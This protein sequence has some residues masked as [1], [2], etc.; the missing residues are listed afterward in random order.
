MPSA[1]QTDSE[2]YHVA[3]ALIDHT[4][5]PH[6]RPELELR[7]LDMNTRRISSEQTIKVSEKGLSMPRF[8]WWEKEYV[9]HPYMREL[10][11]K[12]L[13][14]RFHDIVTNIV[15][16]S[17][18]GKVG[19]E[20]ALSG[21]EW[22]RYQHHVLMEAKARELPY[23]LFLDKRHARDW[24]RDEFT[25][26]VKGTHSAG[27]FQAVKAWAEG[28]GNH[29]FSVVKYGERRFMERFL[30]YGEILV[31][32][33]AAYNHA[34]FNRAQRDDENSVSVFGV[35]T[36]DGKAVPANDLPVWWGNRL[37]MNRYSA[38]TDRDYMLYCMG[39]TLS[40]TLF[41]QFGETY[42]A[43]ILIHD[44]VEFAK[45]M[46]EGTRRRFPS[47]AFVHA[48]GRTTYIDPLNAIPP[49][50]EPSKRTGAIPIPFLKHFRHAYQEE[51]R[52]VWVPTE[53]LRGFEEVLLSIGSIEDIAE[54]IC[55]KDGAGRRA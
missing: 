35:R 53:P 29:R 48:H 9:E 17:E 42:D 25:S 46:D 8:M 28:S 37:S 4:I 51:Y 26:S 5:L 13:N 38:S 16:T 18:D 55:L 30:R 1:P 41:S 2:R 12:D 49:T 39:T 24:N 43:C 10:P 22:L 40:P 45:R 19:M 6:L 32:P 23:P 36:G 14:Q 33:S 27:A 15:K 7:I 50:P 44:L 11:M 47:G 31:R 21:V 34:A 54:I 52:F 3:R 20:V